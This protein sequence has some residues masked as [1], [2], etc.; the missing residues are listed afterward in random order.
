MR[1]QAGDPALPLGSAAASPARQKCR[2][3]GARFQRW[4]FLRAS[5]ERTKSICLRSCPG[6]AAS[7]ITLNQP[8]SERPSVMTVRAAAPGPASGEAGEPRRGRVVLTGA[9]CGQLA[10]WGC[11][12]VPCPC[13]RRDGDRQA[14]RQTGACHH[15]P[16]RA[17]RRTGTPIS[18]T[19][20]PPARLPSRGGRWGSGA[21]LGRRNIRGH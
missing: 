16:Q 20:A 7:C 18:V 2:L 11:L 5:E 6:R 12:P 3:T 1:S 14:A 8:C 10:G 13:L 21:G 9:P 15:G 19:V 4:Y 17:E